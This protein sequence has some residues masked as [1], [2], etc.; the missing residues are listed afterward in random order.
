MENRSRELLKSVFEQ[1]KKQVDT[2]KTFGGINIKVQSSFDEE[3]D[4]EKT[5]STLLR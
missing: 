3:E 1:A 2:T 4:D 5:Q